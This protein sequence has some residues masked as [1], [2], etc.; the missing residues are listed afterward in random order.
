MKIKNIV[1]NIIT[2]GSAKRMCKYLIGML[3]IKNKNTWNLINRY[4]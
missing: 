4:G 3:E 2:V 1:E